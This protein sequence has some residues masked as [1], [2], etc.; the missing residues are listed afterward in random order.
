M[1]Q[2]FC[3]FHYRTIVDSVKCRSYYLIKSDIF[4]FSSKKIY[5]EMLRNHLNCYDFSSFT[6]PLYMIFTILFLNRGGFFKMKR[7]LISFFW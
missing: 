5:I 1:K 3:Y 6:F 2:R 7:K 4:I